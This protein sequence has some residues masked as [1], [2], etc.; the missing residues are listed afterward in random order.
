M[1]MECLVFHLVLSPFSRGSSCGTSTSVLLH[2]RE[3]A[4]HID[5]EE[6]ILYGRPPLAT[7]SFIVPDLWSTVFFKIL[8]LP[9]K[10]LEDENQSSSTPG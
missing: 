6:V 2:L 10:T 3:M 8:Y 7:Y 1:T 5:T 9:A 4:M